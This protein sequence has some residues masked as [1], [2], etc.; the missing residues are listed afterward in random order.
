MIFGQQWKRNTKI[1]ITYVVI[2]I[3]QSPLQNL[4]NIF[5][6][7]LLLAIKLKIQH[8]TKVKSNKK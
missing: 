3:E 5:G 6:Y 7:M 2:M 4:A 1:S 8:F